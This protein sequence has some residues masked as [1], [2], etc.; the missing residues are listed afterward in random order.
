MVDVRVRPRLAV[1]P[2]ARL[3]RSG[4][5]RGAKT[6][7]AIHVRRADARS[8]EHRE[9]VVLLERQLAGRVK[10]EPPGA[11][12]LGEQLARAIDHHA[13][14]LFP[15]ALDELAAAAH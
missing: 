15:I 8:P 7:V 10:A 11:A 13:H 1:G 12:R 2:K 3:E 5:R 14:R 9:R 4:G 6:R